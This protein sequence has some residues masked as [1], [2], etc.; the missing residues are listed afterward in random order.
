V[1]VK[2]RQ[3]SQVRLEKDAFATPDA[4]VAAG[5][6]QILR[7]YNGVHPLPLFTKS[8]ETAAGAEPADEPAARLNLYYRFDVAAEDADAFAARL[9]ETPGVDI[10]YVEPEYETA[11]AIPS[12]LSKDMVLTL[13]CPPGPLIC[14]P[15]PTVGYP[16]L[17]GPLILTPDFSSQQTYL[18]PASNGGI[19]ARFAWT[20]QGGDGAGVGFADVEYGWRIAHEDLDLPVSTPIYGNNTLD[21]HGTAV[22]GEIFA[23]HNGYGVDGI[24]P[25]ANV[26]VL[27]SI[28]GHLLA[29]CIDHAMAILSAGDVMLIE[30]QTGFMPVERVEAN[31]DRIVAAVAKGIVVVEA[32]GNGLY[33]LDAYVRPVSDGGGG[34]VL[35]RAVRD[36]G[37]IIVGA[38]CPPSANFG[39]PRSRWLYSNYGSRV[40]VQGQG[41]EVCTTGYGDL[42]DAGPDRRYTADF[43][44]T[45]AASPQVA[46]AALS[47]QGIRKA[48]GDK[49]L[50]PAAMRTLLVDTGSAQADG[51]YGPATQHIGPEPDMRA[52]IW[53]LYPLRVCKAGPIIK[54]PPAPAVR[55]CYVA[56]TRRQ[57]VL[58]CPSPVVLSCPPAPGGCIAGPTFGCAAAPSPIEHDWEDLVDPV[59]QLRHIEGVGYAFVVLHKSD[60]RA[61]AEANAADAATAASYGYG[62]T[63][64]S[65]TGEDLSGDGAKT[66]VRTPDK[67]RKQSFKPKVERLPR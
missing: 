41:R 35:Q 38:G 22:L 21:E 26:R 48:K 58:T 28:S 46:G 13:L 55:E 50:A 31:Y 57:P 40:D 37:A 63:Y 52:A 4:R 42:F 11:G 44:Q 62:E 12:V 2:F 64:W 43:P 24:A 18:N 51:N 56:P 3:E 59:L 6:A 25:G 17:P 19:N 27:C 53:N 10:A 23:L 49:V 54:C 33:D 8:T 60:A 15:G 14:K 30:L 67:G 1:V 47:I 65:F 61:I 66:V 32:A 9:R 16:C 45:S 29:D 36:S 5:L 39:P 7:E 34:N 20:L